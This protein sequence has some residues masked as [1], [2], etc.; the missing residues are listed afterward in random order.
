ML[1]LALAIVL[2]QDGD[3]VE[4]WLFEMGLELTFE[5]ERMGRE[6]R[7]NKRLPRAGAV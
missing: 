1:A 2:V 4:D 3:F 7:K 6:R 5:S